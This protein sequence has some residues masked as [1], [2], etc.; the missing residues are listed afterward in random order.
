[1]VKKI[2][3]YTLGTISAIA[4]L[5]VSGIKECAEWWTYTKPFL[6]VWFVSLVLAVCIINFNYIR[7]IFYPAFVCLSAWAYKHRIV[8][9]KF[10]RST[11][12]VYKMQNKSYKKLFTY[13]Q[14]LFDMM[15]L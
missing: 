11:H 8:M 3:V 5:A 12:R 7:R 4:G 10:T 6:L 15:Y 1:M 2:I 13:T 14:D 9:T